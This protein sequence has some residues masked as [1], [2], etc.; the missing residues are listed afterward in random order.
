MTPAGESEML[1]EIVSKSDDEH[2]GNQTNSSI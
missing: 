1:E 2:G